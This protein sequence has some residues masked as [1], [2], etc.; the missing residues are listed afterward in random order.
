MVTDAQVRR[1]KRLSKTEETQD[2]AAAKAGMDI[3]TARKYLKNGKL[4]SECKPERTWRTRKDPFDRVWKEIQQQME[5]YP[6]LEAKTIF[7]ALQREYPGEFSDGQLRTLQ[8]H[9]KR[10]RAT[11]GPGR[12][13]FFAQRHVPGRL[14]QS[15]FTHMTELGVTIGRKSFPH[16]LYHFV[17]AYSNWE[18]ATVCYSESF[19]SLSE[20]LQNALWELGGAPLEHRTDRLSTAVNNMTDAKEFTARYESLL[21]HYRMN[22]QKIQA[23]KAN[24]NGDVEQRHHRLKRAIEQALLLRGSRDFGSLPEYKE[25][26]R[27]LLVQLNAGRRERVKTEM[28]YLK[29]LPDAR[30]ESNKRVKVRVDSGS[31]IYVDRNVYSVH[32]RLI[33]EQVE[34]R[35]T[36][37]TVEV[38]YAGQKVE[39]LPRLRGRGK[40]R[41]D[42]RHIID[43]LVRKPGAFSNYRYREELFPTSRFRMT[44]DALRELDRLHANKRYLE[45]LQLAAVEGEA[46]VDGALRR[47]LEDGEIGPGKLNVTAIRRLLPEASLPVTDVAVA[48]VAL[49]SFDELLGGNPAGVTQ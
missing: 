1:L 32:S 37:E 48:E 16:L 24:E 38:W 41:V 10:W 35:L 15:D 19:E 47:V 43:W 36:A 12:E 44:W 28:Q 14:G 27:L 3:K 25:F 26:L 13:V 7:E 33:G 21:R 18:D 23:G 30:L 40:H 17:L 11:E 39:Q 6:G 42:Y 8:R 29:A 45:I 5:E 31:V 46:V 2:L 49:A 34:A 4:P 9:I 20:G 22:G